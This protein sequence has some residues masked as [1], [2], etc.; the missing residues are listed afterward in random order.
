[1]PGTLWVPQATL[2]APFA[3]TDYFYHAKFN[4]SLRM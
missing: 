3:V 4:M 2:Y 1:M